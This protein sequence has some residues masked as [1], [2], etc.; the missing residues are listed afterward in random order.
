MGK[1]VLLL[2]D[3]TTL[4]I[5]LDRERVTIGRRVDN[6]VCLPYPAVSGAHA[7]VVTILDDSFLE[8]LNST[9]GTLVNGKFIAKHF[10]RDRDEID[11]GRQKLVYWEGD[12]LVASVEDAPVRSGR[13]QHARNGGYGVPE[14]VPLSPRPDV[15][16]VP[17]S[18]AGA[19]AEPAA[20]FAP[21]TAW[22]IANVADVGTVRADLSA[23]LGEPGRP[24]DG[25][26]E[27]DQRSFRPAPEPG[28]RAAVSPPP[29]APAGPSVRVATG[30]SAG[31]IVAMT[32]D[33]LVVG[34]VGECIA[35]V[36]RAEVG[37]RLVKLEGEG[38]IVLNSNPL[39]PGGATIRDGDRFEV[40]GTELEFTAPA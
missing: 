15:P 33:E 35:A 36:R 1:L 29:E 31:R 3:G 22:P 10:L 9:N 38:P 8:D 25:A 24:V 17:A 21:R 32:R 20:V 7:A 13:A 39:P 23:L 37:Y 18:A 34:R 4:D 2:P 12:A 27:P 14:V 11:I 26:G 16:P 28:A 30:P 6:D 40:A 19:S 5:P